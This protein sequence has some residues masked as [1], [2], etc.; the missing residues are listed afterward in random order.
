M[1]ND[2]RALSLRAGY[3]TG[4]HYSVLEATVCWKVTQVLEMTEP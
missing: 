4:A 3:V 2:T 1:P